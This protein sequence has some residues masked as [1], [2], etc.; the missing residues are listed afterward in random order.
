M[1]DH[2]LDGSFEDYRLAV[3][4]VGA[5]ED[6]LISLAQKDRPKTVDLEGTKFTLDG[7]FI[8]E[9]DGRRNV[10]LDLRCDGT[11]IPSQTVLITARGTQLKPTRVITN[12]PTQAILEF[13]V[14]SRL[15]PRSLRP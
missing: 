11:I 4:I 15:A 7:A 13:P 1:S 8:S 9:A 2:E 3:R 10:S 6:S 12:H 5:G 14:D